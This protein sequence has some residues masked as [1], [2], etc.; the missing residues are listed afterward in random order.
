MKRRD[1]KGI[2]KHIQCF[3]WRKQ[4]VTSRLPWGLDAPGRAASVLAKRW[5]RRSR[6]TTRVIIGGFVL[7]FL[8]MVWGTWA[9]RS[10]ESPKAAQLGDLVGGFAGGLGFLG[11]VIALWMQTRQLRLQREDLSLTRREIKTQTQVLEAQANAASMNADLMRADL[12][13][14]NLPRVRIEFRIHGALRDASVEA[15]FV[16][17]GGGRAL[18]SSVLVGTATKV[19]NRYG[20]RHW[21]QRMA[22]QVWPKPEESLDQ[23]VDSLRFVALQDLIH[24][25]EGRFVAL[26]AGESVPPS[27]VRHGPRPRA[28]WGR[29]VGVARLESSRG[30]SLLRQHRT[31]RDAQDDRDDDL[32]G[33]YLHERRAR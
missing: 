15:H 10:W 29:L 8:M 13:A 3:R 11:M 12:I 27:T 9:W 21:E 22:A 5:G 24:A 14:R 33:R 23:V 2:P 28:R 6:W 32:S 7:S 4:P 20:L 19:E 17:D 30:C 31:R 16:N 18:L 1:R 25:V 26:D